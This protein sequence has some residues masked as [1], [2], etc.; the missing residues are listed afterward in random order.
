MHRQ[1]LYCYWYRQSVFDPMVHRFYFSKQCLVNWCVGSFSNQHSFRP[2]SILFPFRSTRQTP[3]LF[4]HHPHRFYLSNATMDVPMYLCWLKLG[5]NNQ[6]KTWQNNRNNSQNNIA[7][8]TNFGVNN[9]TND[10]TNG[11]ENKHNRNNLDVCYVSTTMPTRGLNCVSH[12]W[13]MFEPNQF[14]MIGLT[15]WGHHDSNVVVPGHSTI[16]TATTGTT[17]ETTESDQ[18]YT[19]NK[20]TCKY[21]KTMFLTMFLHSCATQ[22]TVLLTVSERMLCTAV[23]KRGC[24]ALVTEVSK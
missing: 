23:C 10:N 22:H 4:Q 20:T 6:H 8:N 16:K 5:C 9:D 13:S 17:K 1:S 24:A 12:F 2:T 14:S 7:N 21:R 18:N 3:C 11:N 15:M 19:N